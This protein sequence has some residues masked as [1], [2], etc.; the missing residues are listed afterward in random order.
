[1]IRV[2]LLRL[3]RDFKGD[4]LSLPGRTLACLAVLALF[5]APLFIR[6][7]YILRIITLT[8]LR[9]LRRQLGSSFRLCGPA[10]GHALFS[11]AAYTAMLNLYLGLP[12]F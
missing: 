1:M 9:R 5:I 6:D 7:T 2:W 11:V 10:I 12:R 4:I 8:P 3:Y